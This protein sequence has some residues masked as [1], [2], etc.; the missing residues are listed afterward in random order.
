MKRAM[1]L[2]VTVT[3]YFI[4]ACHATLNFSIKLEKFMFMHISRSGTLI[5]VFRFEKGGY[6]VRRALSVRRQLLL[7]VPSRVRV[8]V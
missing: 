7:P 2:C 3:K 8:A 6:F 4:D 1:F 5:R